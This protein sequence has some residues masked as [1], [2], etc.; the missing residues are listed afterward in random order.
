M[1]HSGVAETMAIWYVNWAQKY[2]GSLKG[3]SMRSRSTGD[4]R[5]FLDSLEKQENIEPW[6]VKQSRDSLA[7]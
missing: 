2:A 6:Q 1:P 4:V 5:R 3:K 7:V